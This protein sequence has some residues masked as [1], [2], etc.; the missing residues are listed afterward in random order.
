[1]VVFLPNLFISF[2]YFFYNFSFSIEHFHSESISRMGVNTWLYRFLYRRVSMRNWMEYNGSAKQRL[3][4]IVFTLSSHSDLLLLLFGSLQW[5]LWR[6]RHWRRRDDFEFPFSF[7]FTT[8]ETLTW[9]ISRLTSTIK[10]FFNWNQQQRRLRRR[11]CW[12]ILMMLFD[13]VARARNENNNNNRNVSHK[14]CKV[15]TLWLSW[16]ELHTVRKVLTH[17]LLRFPLPSFLRVCVSLNVT[18]ATTKTSDFTCSP[19]MELS[20]KRRIEVSTEIRTHLLT[21]RT[22]THTHALKIL[23]CVGECVCVTSLP[24]PAMRIYEMQN[25]WQIFF[26]V[27]HILLDFVF[28][29]TFAYASLST[30]PITHRIRVLYGCARFCQRTSCNTMR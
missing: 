8:D 19:A 5:W 20:I 12:H 1:M 27:V 7:G 23:F 25:K 14:A 17:L 15:K 11:P 24:P 29:F 22:H 30:S 6:R 4:L 10:I 16:S 26:E 9:H 28:H 13:A 18:F 21:C 3:K 2:F